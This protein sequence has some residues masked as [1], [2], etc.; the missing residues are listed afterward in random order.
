MPSRAHNVQHK[1]PQLKSITYLKKSMWIYTGIPHLSKVHKS[2]SKICFS[3][4]PTLGPVLANQK[5]SE[6]DFRFHK[7]RCKVQ[8]AISTCF[9]ASRDRSRMPGSSE[10]G[11]LELLP[12]ELHSASQ[13]PAN[14]ALNYI[15]EHLCFVSTSF[16]HPLARCNLRYQKSLRGA[17]VWVW[18]GS[19]TSSV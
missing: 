7:R 12:R 9:T 3:E 18:E 16:M 1:E 4:R 8:L 14:M 13:H 5:N 10:G 6:E 11:P 15:W 17:I 2:K 19:K